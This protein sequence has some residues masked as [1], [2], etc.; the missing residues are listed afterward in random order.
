MS[1]AVISRVEPAPER[2]G[3]NIAIGEGPAPVISPTWSIGGWRLCFIRLGPGQRFDPQADGIHYVKVVTGRLA[4]P[5]RGAYARPKVVR[6]TRLIGDHLL[7]TDEG[8]LLA[9]FTQTESTPHQVKSMDEL[10]WVGPFADHLGWRTFETQYSAVTPFFDGA[11]AHLSP[12]FHL[13]DAD[14]SEIAYV[15]VWT[16]GKGVDLSTHNHGHK[17]GPHNPAFAEV[18]WVLFNGTGDGGMYETDEPGAPD[19]IRYPMRCGQEHGPFFHYDL[20]TGAPVLRD[21][22]AV[23]YPW[24]GWQAGTDTIPG[25]AY[26]VVAAFEITVPYAT[27][28]P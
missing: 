3:L 4:E 26:D 7:A 27:V 24:H 17:P 9:L 10:N 8:A 22:G 28:A 13:L 11:D 16:A 20:L 6:D 19:R 15:F 1:G 23:D 25:Q 12:G 14:G 21:N 2:P 5:E 18:H